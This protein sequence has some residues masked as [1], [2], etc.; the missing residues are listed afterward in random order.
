ML[1]M[2][3]ERFIKIDD[4]CSFYRC[5]LY[6]YHGEIKQETEIF[7]TIYKVTEWKSFD[8]K[9]LAH[10]SFFLPLGERKEGTFLFAF[11]IPFILL[12]TSGVNSRF[13]KTLSL[14]CRFSCMTSFCIYRCYKMFFYPSVQ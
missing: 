11:Y 2:C 8:S 9:Y 10:S 13:T 12:P 4:Q 6:F 3:A 5:L 1:K 7:Q 14:P